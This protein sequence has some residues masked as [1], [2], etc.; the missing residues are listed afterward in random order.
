MSV[1]QQGYGDYLYKIALYG[2]LVVLLA[3][4]LL[5]FIYALSISFRPYSEVFGTVHWIPKNPTLDPWR[6]AFSDLA[7][8]LK[9]SFLIATGTAVLSLIIT[10]PGAYVFGRKQFPGKDIAFYAI[11]VALLFP[12][13]LLIVPIV[14]IWND[15]GLY[16][17]IPG[18][19]LAYQVFVTPFAIWILR[20]FFEGLPDNIEEAAQVYGCTQFSAFLR[21]ILPLSMPAIIA[22]GFI[23]FLVGWNDFLFANMLTTGSGPRPAVVQLFISTTGGEQTSWALLMAET[24]LI[25]TPPTILYMI[26]RRY[27]GNAFA[28]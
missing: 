24:I 23:S 11:I 15:F 5:P 16:N 6:T 22:V 9:N 19:W 18:L 28:T 1:K 12:Y 26:S 13:I 10:I 21:V 27:L 14:D 3:M 25:G 2:T 20:D 4:A 8:P 7:T 17:T